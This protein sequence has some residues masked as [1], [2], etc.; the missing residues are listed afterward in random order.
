ML[1]SENDAMGGIE[2]GGGRGRRAK[3]T[4]KVPREQIQNN[5]L[6]LPSKQG[7]GGGGGGGG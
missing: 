4:G 5:S 3:R 1:V 7:G 2:E 6:S